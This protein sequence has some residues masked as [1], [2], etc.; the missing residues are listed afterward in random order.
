MKTLLRIIHALFHCIWFLLRIT[1]VSLCYLWRRLNY[2]LFHTDLTYTEIF[3]GICYEGWALTLL[4]WRPELFDSPSYNSLEYQASQPTWGLIFLII[5]SLKIIGVML[6]FRLFRALGALFGTALWGFVSVAFFLAGASP[7][8][9]T[10]YTMFAVTCFL[11]FLRHA[12]RQRDHVK[13]RV[14]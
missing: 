5:G 12:R 13:E 4:F 10:I 11:T 1:W 14:F 2:I 8:G 7:I 3:M 6:S 9:L